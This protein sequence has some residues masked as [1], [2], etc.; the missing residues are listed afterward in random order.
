[1][2]FLHTD[3]F[4]LRRSRFLVLAALLG[5]LLGMIVV[6]LLL[7]NAAVQLPGVLFVLVSLHFSLRRPW[8]VRLQRLQQDCWE[9]QW[10][11]GRV[12]QDRL[13]LRRLTPVVIV[14]SPGRQRAPA[15]LL[16]PDAFCDADHKKLRAL[17]R[18]RVRATT[19]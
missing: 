3:C 15:I 13:I 12:W 10:S 1:M 8:P 9:I 16:L 18:H 17:L 14:C 7:E 6:L 19:C 5:H 11:N 2:P 4:R